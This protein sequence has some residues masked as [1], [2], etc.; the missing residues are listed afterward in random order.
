MAVP[1]R[2]S[3]PDQ[4][5]HYSI[6][7]L[8]GETEFITEERERRIVNYLD[9]R[10]WFPV[11]PGAASSRCVQQF[12]YAYGY[13]T[14]SVSDK[15]VSPL[16]DDILEIALYL[17]K[18]GW[19]PE[20]KLQCI[21]NEYHRNQGISAHTDSTEFGPVVVTISL[22]EDSVMIFTHKSDGRSEEVYL[23][24]RGIL[25]LE[26]EARYDFKHCI[27][28]NVTYFTPTG[29]KV[30]K[31]QEYRRISLTYRTVPDR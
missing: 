24:R 28:S 21:V 17:Q 11:T 5:Q 19:L 1:S 2:P 22:L 8:V 18:T 16:E 6:P 10:E 9:R 13:N 27:S 29:Q 7:G 23:P 31:R 30:T 25:V 12:G 4:D 15:P 20:G 26:G 3:L 14:K